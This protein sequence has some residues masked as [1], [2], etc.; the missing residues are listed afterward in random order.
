MRKSSE[1]KGKKVV[2]TRLPF[3]DFERLDRFINSIPVAKRPTRD[4]FIAE[5]IRESI[6][7]SSAA[8]I[9]EIRTP[10]KNYKKTTTE[11]QGRVTVVGDLTQSEQRFLIECLRIYRSEFGRPLQENVTF[12]GIGLSAVEA[13]AAIKGGV[14]HEGRNIGDADST[15]PGERGVAAQLDHAENEANMLPK[16]ANDVIEELRRDWRG[17]QATP[18]RAFQG[19]K[20][21][22][23]RARG[24]STDRVTDAESE[25]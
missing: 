7:R 11:P 17:D 10:A 16:T 14:V 25:K 19:R 22:T 23:R 3:D 13:I 24:G 18:D 21:S 8:T 12:F 20:S 9:G 2:T 5:A 4:G 6:E 15:S 1:N